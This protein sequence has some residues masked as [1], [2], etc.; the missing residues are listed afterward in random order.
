[1]A[2]GLLIVELFIFVFFSHLP[3]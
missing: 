1:M 2:L 3:W